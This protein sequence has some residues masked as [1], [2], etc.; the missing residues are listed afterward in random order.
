MERARVP[1]GAIV[2]DPYMGSGTTGVACIRTGR[3][4]IGIEI[5]PTH[6]ATSCKR[7]DNELQRMTLPM[8]V[9]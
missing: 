7:I 5:D 4:F 3:R 6:Y 8:E 9:A 2:L 1:A